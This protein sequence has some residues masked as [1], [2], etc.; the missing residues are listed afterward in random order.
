MVNEM[1]AH[2]L[3][4]QHHTVRPSTPSMTG[5]FTP[6]SMLPVMRNGTS[7]LLVRNR[8]PAAV[9]TGRASSRSAMVSNSISKLCLPS[10][11]ARKRC[12]GSLSATAR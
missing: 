11:A 3:S 12:E 4:G 10:S 7:V 9:S 1:G 5:A 2:R 8:M 6:H